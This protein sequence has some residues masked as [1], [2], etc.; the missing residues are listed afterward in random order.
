LEN[1]AREED[2]KKEIQLIGKRFKDAADN[3]EDAAKLL[4]ELNRQYRN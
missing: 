3:I 1:T 2:M 4:N